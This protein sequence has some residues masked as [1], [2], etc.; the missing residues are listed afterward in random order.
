MEL[1][2]DLANTKGWFVASLSSTGSEQRQNE[3]ICT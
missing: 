2:P 1:G 3:L